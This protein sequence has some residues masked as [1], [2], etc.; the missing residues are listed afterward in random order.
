MKNNFVAYL[1]W[2]FFGGTGLH[3]FYAGNSNIG[4]LTLCLWILTACLS[5]TDG[6]FSLAL[7]MLFLIG[8]AFFIPTWVKQTNDKAKQAQ[9]D[10]IAEAIKKARVENA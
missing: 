2:L 5:L 10:M 7:F 3:A 6:G 8:Q 4:W 9:A 1:L